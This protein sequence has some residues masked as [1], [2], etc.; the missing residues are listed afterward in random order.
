LF[1]FEVV[2]TPHDSAE[3]ATQIKASKDTI[4]LA[5]ELGANVR[6]NG[7][8]N[9]INDICGKPK[10][11]MTFKVSLNEGATSTKINNTSGVLNLP[12]GAQA[13]FQVSKSH[14]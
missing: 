10:H 6:M 4:V 5:K 2:F 12:G 3:Y 13:K 11:E 8:Q 14:N 7:C 9:I 1:H